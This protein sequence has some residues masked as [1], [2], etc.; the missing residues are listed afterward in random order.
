MAD[1]QLLVAGLASV[2]L[3]IMLALA[4]GGFLS[5]NRRAVGRSVAVVERMRI[6]GAQTTVAQDRSFMDR[7]AR[8]S[9]SGMVVLARKLSSRGVAERLQHR[10]DVAGNPLGWTVD[11]LL[12]V[13]GLGLIVMAALGLLLGRGQP[14]AS[15]LLALVFGAAGFFLPNVLLYNRGLKRQLVIRRALPDALDLLVISVQAGLGFDAAVAQVA[16][17]TD[18]A[19]AAEFFR[20][21]QEMQIGKSRAEAFRA[22]ADRNDVNELRSFTQAV[23]QAD[24]L[25]VPI[26]RVLQEQA[27]EMRIKRRQ[28]AEEQAQKVPVK[29]LFPLIAF[30]L[31]AL[32][33]VIIGPGAL[34]ISKIFSH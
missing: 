5:P 13:K 15:L 17:N 24:A 27:T 32:F 33:V 14:G 18:G 30:I 22:L 26:A 3:A 12:G 1:Q 31:P 9:L 8:P 23:I 10:L 19:L 2:S 21:M 25:G 29:I 7:I 6:S 28:A 16:R 11:R 34:S 4:A 20:L